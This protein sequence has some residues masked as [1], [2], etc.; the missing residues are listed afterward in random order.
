M[1]MYK[2]MQGGGAR[3]HMAIKMS[4][5][6]SFVRGRQLEGTYSSDPDV[7]IWPITACRVSCGWGNVPARK[8]PYSSSCDW[9]PAEPP[10]LDT[11]AKSFR[12][13]C[14]QRI[15]SIEECKLA[16]YKEH[17]V[18]A[19]FNI[20]SQWFNAKNGIIEVPQQKDEMVGSHSIVLVGYD[21]HYRSFRLRNS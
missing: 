12:S 3:M 18:L 1:T 5:L 16:L 17:P 6:Y 10:G 2:I 14:Y 11:I 21:N 8:W 4:R 15:R 9:P 13:M 7:G 19:A 20:T